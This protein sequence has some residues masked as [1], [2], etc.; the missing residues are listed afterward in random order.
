MIL[1]PY[2]FLSLFLL[3]LFQ[4]RFDQLKLTLSDNFT[5]YFFQLKKI[6]KFISLIMFMNTLGVK[7]FSAVEHHS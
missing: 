6:K 2:S 5:Y 4:M 7:Y 3:S 1:K